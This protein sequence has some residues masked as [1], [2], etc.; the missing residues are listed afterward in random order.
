MARLTDKLKDSWPT[1]GAIPSGLLIKANY[2]LTPLPI[3]PL[4]VNLTQTHWLTMTHTTHTLTVYSQIHIHSSFPTHTFPKK[5]RHS[6]LYTHY[7]QSSHSHMN[8]HE[9]VW[10]RPDSLEMKLMC[11]KL[12]LR[13][14]KSSSYSINFLFVIFSSYIK[15]LVHSKKLKFCYLLTFM[16]FQNYLKS[17]EQHIWTSEKSLHANL[18]QT[19]TVH[20]DNQKGTIKKVHMI[21]DSIIPALCCNHIIDSMSWKQE[22]YQWNY[23]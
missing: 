19:A 10:T 14:T 21:V 2:L 22:L 1:K 13:G 20:S 9:T 7:N 5:Y 12:I 17:V 3:N 18:F 8:R 23:F 15:G 4:T 6:H 16:S 11:E